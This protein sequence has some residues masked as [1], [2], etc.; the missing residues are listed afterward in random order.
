MADVVTCGEALIAATPLYR[1]RLDE[2]LDLKLHVVGAES[3]VAIGLSRL[4]ISTAFWGTVGTDPFGA[5]IQARLAAEGVDLT[6]LVQRPEPTGL[7]FKEWYGL[8]DDPQVYYYRAGSAGSAWECGANVTNDLKDVRWIHCSGITAMIGLESRRSLGTVITAAKEL[9]IPVSLDVNL[10]TKLAPLAHWR[11]V[12]NPLVPDISLIFS[13]TRELSQLWTVQDPLDWFAHEIARAHTVL[14]VK[15]DQHRATAYQAS[16][17]IARAN[18]W[19]V[20]HVVD[21]VGAGD[22]FAAGVI[23]ARMKGWEWA[24]ALRLGT[25][26]GALAVSHPGDFE[27]YPYWREVTDLWKGRWIDR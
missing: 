9:G 3:N 13:T 20:A 14:L 22:G 23:A 16:G 17:P 8:G 19:P 27:G 15:D 11:Q 4:G 26:V 1:G 24:D 6:H 5:I 2:S 10:R 18:P 7:L 25:L 12:L 21:P